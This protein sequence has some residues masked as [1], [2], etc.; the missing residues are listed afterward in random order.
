MGT[1]FRETCQHVFSAGKENWKGES[2]IPA[3]VRYLEGWGGDSSSGDLSAYPG[4]LGKRTGR[5]R[6]IYQLMSGNWK[7]GLRIAVRETCQHVR[8]CWERELEGRE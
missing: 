8:E 2:N 1:A 4:V 5:K 3:N 7:D 6:V